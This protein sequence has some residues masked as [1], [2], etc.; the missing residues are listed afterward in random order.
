ME[1]N[2]K[3]EMDWLSLS[4]VFLQLKMIDRG[5]RYLCVL[6]VCVYVHYLCVHY[7]SEHYLC[8]HCLCVPYLWVHYISV[9][10]PT[11]YAN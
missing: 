3:K 2:E 8:V 10:I 9:T 11:L 6:Y 7:L 4:F 5:T 1:G